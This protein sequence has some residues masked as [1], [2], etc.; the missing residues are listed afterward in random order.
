MKK[1][2][3]RAAFGKPDADFVSCVQYTLR[4]LREEEERPMKRKLSL[5]AAIAVAACLIVATAALAAAS[6]WGLFDFL[7]QGG[8][9]GALPEAAEI[10]ATDPPQE[11]GEGEL[12]SFKLREAVYDGE[13]VYMVVD[14]TPADGILL[15]GPGLLPP[16][17]MRDL[18]KE[19]SDA[20]TIGEYAGENDLQMAIVGISTAAAAEGA[21][22]A[23]RSS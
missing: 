11:G 20:M 5:S 22:D 23:S 17:A 16:D 1:R 3:F 14:A 9:S 19:D 10:V 13:Y 7:N 2:D 6:H 8:D 18:T 12:A 21:E 4:R 15:L